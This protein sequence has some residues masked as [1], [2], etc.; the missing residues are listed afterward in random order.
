M[1]AAMVSAGII[2]KPDQ[3]DVGDGAYKRC[4][5]VYP[6][7]VEHYALMDT[8][9]TYDL[10]HVLRNKMT[11]DNRKIYELER[12]VMPVLIRMEHRGVAVD[13]EK[14]AELKYKYEQI[15]EQRRDELIAANN[16][17]EINFDSNRQ[18]ADLL[19]AQG[20][21]LWETTDT[22][23]IRVD[24][25]VLEKFEDEFPIVATLAEYRQAC[26]FL[27]TYIGPMSGRD[28]IHPNFWQIGARTGRMSSSNPNAQNIP[29]R[30]GTEVREIF[31]PRDGYAFIVADYSSIELRL[32]AYYMNHEELWD[33]INNGDPF[34]WLG[35]RIYGTS[36]QDEWPVTRSKLKNGYYAL[37][38]GAG[39][40][41]L[42]A[43]IGGG[44]TPMQ[45]KA[46]A[47][48]MKA[49]LGQPYRVLNKRIRD[50]IEA[51]GFVKTLGRRTQYVNR[52]KSYV[53]LNALIQGS[54]ADIMKWGL[55][56]AAE[57]LKEFDGHPVLVVHDEIVAEVP[58]QH[59]DAALDALCQAMVSA[60]DILPLKV[61]GKV[62]YNSYAE[63]K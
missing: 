44:M 37:T 16:G 62:A 31:V 61:D 19:I 45:G 27:S 28:S 20:V 43:T 35:E 52:D 13:A 49:A 42:A 24:K 6:D 10:Y 7:L 29:S 23:E 59:A 25:W 4:W 8:Q 14:V 51:Q 30:A 38:Y 9:Y 34:L 58:V 56:N 54:A 32:I 57:A 50:Q 40:P 63:G 15:H 53:G 41:K 21:P 5:E 12:A 2:R 55:V 11:D 39:G 1:R 33:I 3:K 17:E 47:K 22:G 36:N 46:L 18:I 26:K 60:T 48:D